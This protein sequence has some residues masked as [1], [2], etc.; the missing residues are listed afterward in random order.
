ME[1]LNEAPNDLKKYINW[2]ESFKSII[3]KIG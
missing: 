1:D 3:L 2:R